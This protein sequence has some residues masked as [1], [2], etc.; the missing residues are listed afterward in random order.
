MYKGGYEQ[1][2]DET[3]K[4]SDEELNIAKG[5]LYNDDTTLK[6]EG[7]NK[8]EDSK[9]NKLDGE[10]VNETEELISYVEVEATPVET[11]EAEE[12]E[13]VETEVTAETQEVG[14]E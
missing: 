12:T 8:T 14:N 13:S 7:D 4:Q 5:V 3:S 2:N 10:K 9:T 11:V 6:A 1:V